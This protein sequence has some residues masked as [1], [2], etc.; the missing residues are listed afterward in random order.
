MT[1]LISDFI[2]ESAN[3][4]AED[5]AF[6][7]ES[8]A[9]SYER[10]VAKSNQLAHLL[11]DQGLRPGDRVGIF[12]PRVLESA[13]AVYG[14]LKS[15]AAFVPIDPLSPPLRVRQ[16]IRDCGI[17]H[18]ITGTSPFDSLATTLN[19]ES[20]LEA[21]VGVE[22]ADGCGRALPWASTETF[23]ESTPK[24][25][26]KPDHLAYVMYTSG[27]T[28]TPKG[29]MHT[30]HSGASYAE[31]SAK[32]YDVGIGDCIGNHSPLH[33]DMSTFGYLTAPLVG[34]T[35]VI[36]PAAYTKLPASLS[37][38]IESQGMTIWYSVPF[39]LIQILQ[40]GVLE[41]RDLGQLRWVLFGGEPFPVKHLKRLIR[42]LPG[43]QFSNVYGPAEVNQCTYFHLPR[44]FGQPQ[45]SDETA[46]DASGGEAN[47]DSPREL[48]VPIP[49]G[50]TWDLT[51]GIVLREGREASIG[52]SGEL[53]IR[54]PT[55]MKGYWGRPEL[56]EQA[57]YHR[58]SE[59]GDDQV[60][61]RTGDH[62]RLNPDGGFTFLGRQDRQIKIRGHRVEL[63]E[64]EA[65]VAS[66]PAVVEAGVYP[67]RYDDV[68]VEIG[69]TV[70]TTETSTLTGR[71]IAAY[72]SEKLPAYAVPKIIRIRENLPRTTSGK[73]DRR[74]LSEWEQQEHA[75]K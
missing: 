52:E 6:R 51:E 67:V 22:N 17:R 58:K 63:D 27:S 30:H 3:R 21:V 56:D 19:D 11:I 5:D 28:G 66:H 73:I 49:I 69:A 41:K 61:Y 75:P 7:C 59:S 4:S 64:I 32:T 70:R 2:D 72:A 74:K 23:P 36:I 31:L 18:L 65:A 8:R 24:L 47:D 71:E 16:I 60:F 55:M 10:L 26:I 1:R 40:R 46:K 45:D 35:T 15:G 62:V 20:S 25:A 68:S 9:I 44:R 34:A 37:S 13:I 33:F 29:I 57:F 54:S 43:A 12:L 14:I 50:K 42:M 48:P 53:L 39:A 38:L